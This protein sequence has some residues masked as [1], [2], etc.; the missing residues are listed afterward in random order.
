[1][2]NDLALQIQDN[3]HCGYD[4]RAQNPLVQSTLNG[5]L[6]YSI[7]YSGGCLKDDSGNYCTDSGTFCSLPRA[8]KSQVLPM[9]LRTALP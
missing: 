6:A 1:M 4:L 8:Y 5:L 2:M 3:S 7:L 9:L